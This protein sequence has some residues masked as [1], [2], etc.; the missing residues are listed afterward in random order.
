VRCSAQAPTAVRLRRDFGAILNL[1]RA[2]ALLHRATRQL[3]KHEKIIATLDDY[4]VVRDLVAH[5]VA[6]GVEATISSSI[7]ETVDAIARRTPEH[8]TGTASP[9]RS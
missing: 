3:D 9:S 6:E 7:R 2:H 8:L 1:V 4:T 5:L